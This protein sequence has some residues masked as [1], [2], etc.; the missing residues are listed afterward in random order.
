MRVK[1]HLVRLI[2]NKKYVG[3]NPIILEL[4][5]ELF[6]IEQAHYEVT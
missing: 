3:V 4:K 2:I 1:R 5:V 6:L